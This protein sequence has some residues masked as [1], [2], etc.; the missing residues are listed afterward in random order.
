[1]PGKKVQG[2]VPSLAPLWRGPQPC[3]SNTSHDAIT[4]HL[5]ENFSVL[6]TKNNI[7]I[8]IMNGFPFERGRSVLNKTEI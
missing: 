5:V 6:T 2:L 4:L 3:F 7:Q 1:M 8:K